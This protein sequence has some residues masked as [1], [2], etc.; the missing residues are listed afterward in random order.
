MLTHQG[1]SPLEGELPG[2]QDSDQWCVKI[3]LEGGVVGVE[4]EG[5]QT[6]TP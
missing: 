1:P 6:L 5:N 4:G 3:F 2:T